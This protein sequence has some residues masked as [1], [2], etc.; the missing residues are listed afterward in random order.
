[1]A[2]RRQVLTP[3]HPH[4]PP[5]RP[6]TPRQRPLQPVLKSFRVGSSP[7]P[8]PGLPSL[9][10]AGSATSLPWPGP[11]PGRRKTGSFRNNPSTCSPSP[12][13]P[14][15]L[16]SPSPPAPAAWEQ[17]QTLTPGKHQSAAAPGST[18]EGEAGVGMIPAPQG[19]SAPPP[20]RLFGP[21]RLMIWQFP[22]PPVL[23]PAPTLLEGQG[24]WGASDR[25]AS[26][27]RARRWE[28]DLI[29]FGA[30][31]PDEEISEECEVPRTPG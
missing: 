21:S 2:G 9:S 25:A 23:L 14:H 10:S 3:P 18:Q 11:H 12:V 28:K 7:D 13:P 5:P 6:L 4:P 27:P 19:S 31:S 15:P 17:P 24:K 16:L 26:R 20:V 1:M 8:R 29:P 30:L 22:K